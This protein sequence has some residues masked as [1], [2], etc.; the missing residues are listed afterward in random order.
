MPIYYMMTNYLSE[1][2]HDPYLVCAISESPCELY[3][4]AISHESS[5]A[6]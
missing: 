2:P 6:N 3:K 4:R 5:P 1:V